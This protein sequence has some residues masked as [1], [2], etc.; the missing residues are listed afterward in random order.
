MPNPFYRGEHCG[1]REQEDLARSRYDTVR[2]AG[3]TWDGAAYRWR[4]TDGRVAPNQH[5]IFEHLRTGRPLP[6]IVQE[7]RSGYPIWSGDTR[8]RTAALRLDEQNMRGVFSGWDWRRSRPLTPSV[9]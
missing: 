9:A 5:I 3:W 1:A 2:A 8:E 6:T 7:R 4:H